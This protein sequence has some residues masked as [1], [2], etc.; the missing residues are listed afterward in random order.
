MANELYMSE[1]GFRHFW[2]KLDAI[3]DNKVDATKVATASEL[4]LVKA[5]TGLNVAG[6]G[7]LSVKFSATAVAGSAVE[8]NDA[9]LSDARTPLAHTH[10]N[11]SND[12]KIATG[13]AIAEG[14]NLV[15]AGADGAVTK[16]TLAFTTGTS[17]FLRED[18][19]FAAPPTT[20]Q[21]TGASADSAGTGGT[22]PAPKQGEQT[23][24]LSGAG[25]WVAPNWLTE[26]P[27][28]SM[29]SDDA[30]TAT[31]A[32]GGTF[33]AVGAI[34]KDANG[35]VT[36]VT[37][38]TVTVPNAV[39]SSS[40]AGLMS[41]ADKSK[42]D[43]FQAASNY[44]LKSDIS[45]VYKYKG[46][47]DNYDALPDSDQAVG[48]VYNLSD[49]GM[50]YVWTGD[51]WDALGQVFTIQAMGTGLIDEIMDGTGVGG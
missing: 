13:T 17:N 44:A 38:R 29:G 39:A 11:I 43:A 12:G 40:T 32:F 20:A 28:I 9:R 10:G 21:M 26:H 18:G 35:H 5:G 2:T 34:E 49:T 19:T 6:D 22:V 47:V 37:T 46:S 48:D 24:Y 16:S 25:T 33:T 27:T 23:Y 8:A 42:L 15:I 1:A 50:N 45:T 7:A 31:P 51:A 41:G 3:L 36:K 14:N 4:G 30:D